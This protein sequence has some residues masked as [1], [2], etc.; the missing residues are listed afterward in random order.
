MAVEHPM[1]SG[2]KQAGRQP[3]ERG[4]LIM[5]KLKWGQ[6][7][8]N[9]YSLPRQN[10]LEGPPPEYYVED[11]GLP[12]D[13]QRKIFKEAIRQKRQGVSDGRLGASVARALCLKRELVARYLALKLADGNE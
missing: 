5:S 7:F 11:S 3:A 10:Y 12:A 9:S 4:V 6:R 8:T 1:E 13:I 2:S